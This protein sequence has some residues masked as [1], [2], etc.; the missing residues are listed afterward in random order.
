MNPL[1]NYVQTVDYITVFVLLK[2]LQ[3]Y[4]VT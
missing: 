1:T 2:T 4:F 3:K